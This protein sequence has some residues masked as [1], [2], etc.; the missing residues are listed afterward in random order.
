MTFV[1]ERYIIKNIKR[2]YKKLLY[3]F[4]RKEVNV[5][6]NKQ[7]IIELNKMF[8]NYIQESDDIA[9]F[10]EI[11]LNYIENNTTLDFD[12]QE[13]F[14]KAIELVDSVLENK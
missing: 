5:T 4:F 14:E 10:Y 9:T 3:K 6:S 13:Q 7:L 1:S 2:R 11:A 8:C 12:N